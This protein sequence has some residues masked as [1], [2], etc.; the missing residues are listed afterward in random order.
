MAHRRKKTLFKLI[1]VAV[2]A[3]A[4]FL[5]IGAFAMAQPG[6]TAAVAASPAGSPA[7]RANQAAAALADAHPSDR[8]VAFLSDAAQRETARLASNPRPELDQALNTF[9]T[10]AE[11]HLIAGQRNPADAQQLLRDLLQQLRGAEAAAPRE[12]PQPTKQPQQVNAFGHDVVVEAGTTVES[13]SV[14]GGNLIVR[15]H[16]LGDA[17]AVGG[18]TRLEEGAKVDGDAVSVGG[19]VEAHPGARIEGDTVT[20]G[21]RFEISDNAS[22]GGDRTQVGTGTWA[23]TLPFAHQEVDHGSQFLSWVG[24]VVKTIGL[25]F[26]MALLGIVIAALMPKRTKH[27]IATIRRK[28]VLSFFSGLLT[29]VVTVLA[30]VVL[31][32]TLIGIPLVPLLWLGVGLAVLVGMTGV[33]CLVGEVMPGKGKAQRT[34]LRCLVLGFAL[35]T[36]VSLLPLGFLLIGLLTALA[37]GSVIISRVG[38]NEP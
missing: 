37:L 4:S 7:V 9:S 23:G 35:L 30:S 16:V 29:L 33:A 21:G 14:V 2:V 34:A 12:A 24:S 10:R 28:P 11:E 25:G 27:I 19:N 3:M 18:N 17:V 8:A 31:T 1:G 26:V 32:V 38:A 36:V 5:L 13:A 20:V 6:P 15:G 22:V